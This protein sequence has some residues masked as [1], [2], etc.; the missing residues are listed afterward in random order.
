VHGWMRK[1]LR[2]RRRGGEG[3]EADLKGPST[4]ATF[5]PP[6]FSSSAAISAFSRIAS[7]SLV[8]VMWEYQVLKFSGL[9]RRSSSVVRESGWRMSG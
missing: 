9:R 6:S 4:L 1:E 8:A 3:R 5:S 7:L 2:K